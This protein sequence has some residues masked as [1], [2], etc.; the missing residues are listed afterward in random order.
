[1]HRVKGG[2]A[3]HGDH[4]AGH[5][6]FTVDIAYHHLGFDQK[7][8]GNGP[9]TGASRKNGGSDPHV[10]PHASTQNS[11]DTHGQLTNV[12][13]TPNDQAVNR[14]Q[15]QSKIPPNQLIAASNRSPQ[16]GQYPLG[17]FDPEKKKQSPS[18]HMHT[19]KSCAQHCGV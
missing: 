12:S 9:A 1:L 16:P 2:A 8:Y 19:H 14:S 7:A 10:G 5:L 6:G 17:G 4:Y 3:G 15:S 13:M 18:D 11:S